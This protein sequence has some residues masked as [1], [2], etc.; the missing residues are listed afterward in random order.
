MDMNSSQKPCF[1]ELEKVFPMGKNGLREV[2]PAC[3]ECAEKT[4]CL[5]AALQTK[6]GLGMRRE[7]LDRSPAGGL[8]G[9]LR[10]WSERKDISRRMKERE[11]EERKG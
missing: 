1:G 7:I 4:P 3:F 6:E 2:V 10:L 11:K 5:Q 9:R 8:L